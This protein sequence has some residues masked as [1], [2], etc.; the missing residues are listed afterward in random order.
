MAHT[1]HENRLRYFEDQYRVTAD[2]VIPFVEQS[3]PIERG[4][5]VLEIGCAE[6]GVLKAFLERGA[7]TVGV[8]RNQR[9][10]E[11]GKQFLSDAMQT[12][13]LR[14]L[15]QD[16]QELL[17]REEFRGYFDLIVL[18]DVIEHVEDRPALFSM[19]EQLLRPG[20]R[21][22]MAFPPW[23]MPF[24]GHQQ[25]CRS[26]FLSRT[27]YF[28]LLPTPAY[29]AVLSAFSEKPA[30]IE[31]LLATKRTGLSSTEFQSLVSS[32]GYQVLSERMYLLNP[33]YTYRFGVAPRVQAGWVA[34]R[35]SL[36]DFVTSC[37]YYTLRPAVLRPAATFSLGLAFWLGLSGSAS[38]QS[39]KGLATQAP[40]S[41]GATEV[42]KEGFQ[43]PVAKDPES[44]DGQTF[45][46]NAG[47]FLSAGNSRSLAATAAADYFLRRST[48]QF[49]ALAAVNYGR[50][51]DGPDTPSEVSVENY[52]A[53]VRYD[54]FFT[55]GL[56]GFA[57]VSARRDRFQG[58]DLRLNFDPGLAYYFIDEKGHRFWG[59]LGYDLQ[60]DIRRDEV[61]DASLLD[62][63]VDDLEK[64]E[65][66]HGARLFAGYDNQLSE[67]VK[68]NAGVEYLQNVTETE[69]ARL[70]IDLGLT[71]QLNSDFSLATTLSIDYDNNPLPGIEK[72][73]VVTA[74]NLVYTLTQ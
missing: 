1:Y 54:Y 70:N 19:M 42:A 38:A 10:L 11:L 55:G 31:S 64:S 73:D 47:G 16:A 18:K 21:V 62:P 43:A 51:A 40:A 58:L 8:D 53:R 72:T 12:G 59:E 26:W 7:V 35:K 34:A 74:L 3:G 71:S 41:A 17:E 23:R 68:F 36:R 27:P 9:R 60:Y 61:V 13:T 20:G 39:P 63:L 56:A 57:S 29:R 15:H 46:V 6:A 48:S 37:A 32:A 4:A 2:H 33:M 65:V 49:S 22:F 30:R 44:K 5:R 28:H 25:I 50:S 24:G 67:A 14:L 69:N 45:K 52:Q 66:R